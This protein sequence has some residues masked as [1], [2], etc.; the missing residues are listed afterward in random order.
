MSFLR[1]SVK[2]KVSHVEG[3]HPVCVGSV[4]GRD[5]PVRF[6]SLV[7]AADLVWLQCSHSSRTCCLPIFQSQR[8]WSALL[9]ETRRLGGLRSAWGEGRRDEGSLP[10]QAR[11]QKHIIAGGMISS[12][13]IIHYPQCSAHI[14]VSVASIH[15]SMPLH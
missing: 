13:D 1:S 3:V 15:H 9:M 5:G 6:L 11:H 14:G 2:V 4:G 12:V 10:L 7:S 8:Y